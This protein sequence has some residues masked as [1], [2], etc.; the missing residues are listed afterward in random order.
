MWSKIESNLIELKL[1]ELKLIELKLIEL[2]LIEL[3]AAIVHAILQRRRRQWTAA[4][5]ATS[6]NGRLARM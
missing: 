4:V 5:A 3:A 1:I 6:L 2:K